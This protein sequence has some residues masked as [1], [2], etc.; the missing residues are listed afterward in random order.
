MR[1]FSRKILREAEEKHADLVG[2]LDSWYKTALRGEWKSLADVRKSYPAADG[3]GKHT[4]FNIK[5]NSYRLIVKIEYQ[6]HLIFIKAV[7]T[8][9]EYDKG[10]WK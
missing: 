3:V 6:K 9:A 1:I 2:V 8:H 5:G 4:V 7:L 10:A